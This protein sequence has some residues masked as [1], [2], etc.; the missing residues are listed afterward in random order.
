MQTFRHFTYIAISA[1][2]CL[3][4]CGTIVHGSMQ[5]VSVSSDPPGAIVQVDGAGSYKTPTSVKLKRKGDHVIAFSMDGY[6]TEQ[7]VVSSVVTGAFAGNILFGGI[8]GGAVDMASGGAYRLEPNAVAVSMRPLGAGEVAEVG[9]PL[10]L[11]PEARLQN[12]E[13]LH[14]SGSITDQEYQAMRKLIL[15]EIVGKQAT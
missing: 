6:H 1:A 9:M 4:G 14:N 15:D 12:L 8:I 5:N 13:R 7:V 3:S 2:C 10:A 11:T